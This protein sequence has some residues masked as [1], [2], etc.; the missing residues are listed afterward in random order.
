MAPLSQAK[1]GRKAYSPFIPRQVPVAKLPPSERER[2]TASSAASAGRISTQLQQVYRSFSRRSSDE[3]LGAPSVRQLGMTGVSDTLQRYRKHSAPVDEEMHIVRGRR[4]SRSIDASAATRWQ[5]ASTSE[6]R[7][8]RPS[9]VLRRLASVGT[10]DPEIKR[11]VAGFQN[12]TFERVS[13]APATAAPTFSGALPRRVL[14]DHSTLSASCYPVSSPNAG[15]VPNRRPLTPKSEEAPQLSPS[16]THVEEQPDDLPQPEANFSVAMDNLMAW[17]HP[18]GER[19]LY[20]ENQRQTSSQPGPL[21]L[22]ALPLAV[23]YALNHVRRSIN[24]LPMVRRGRKNILPAMSNA[25][26]GRQTLVLD[27]DETLM[28]CSP[29]PIPGVQADMLVVFE[30]V[31]NKGHVYYRPYVHEFLE[32]VAKEFEVV[33][34]TASTQNYAD[35]VLDSL[36]PEGRL[37]AHRLYRHHCTPV[38]GGTYLKDLRLLGRDLRTTMLADNS[39][40]SLTLQLD[41]GI[42]VMSFFGKDKADTELVDLLDLLKVL[43]KTSNVAAHLNNRYSL[44]TWISNLPDANTW[45]Y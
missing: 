12:Q 1:P 27:L 29:E 19:D 36:D 22:D 24:Q 13:Q 35:Q 37:F 2:P 28:H 43:N 17:R 15:Y 31:M 20:F 7:R 21:C 16:V 38:F 39:P 40:I 45:G 18:G 11:F 26:R 5:A 3:S 30:D 8:R 9:P 6:A 42:P 23:R 34:F 10:S 33:I 32:A 14:V 44:R 41:N 4:A 25:H